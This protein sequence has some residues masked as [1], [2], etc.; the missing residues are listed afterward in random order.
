MTRQNAP[1]SPSKKATLAIPGQSRL[2][3]S[4][5]PRLNQPKGKDRRRVHR[6]AR[7]QGRRREIRMVGRIRIVLR[8]Q[9]QA[10]V[11]DI[12]HAVASRR[13]AVDEVAGVKLYPRLGGFNRQTTAADRL[14]QPA[15]RFN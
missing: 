8:L 3:F 15:A 13:A 5:S 6:L 7:P 1:A 4:V 2:T 14:R 12:L 9:A 10:A 11:F